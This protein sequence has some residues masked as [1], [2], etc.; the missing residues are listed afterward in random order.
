MSN[1]N[2]ASVARLLAEM[3]GKANDVGSIQKVGDR[4]I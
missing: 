4:C 2:I 3:L 1:R